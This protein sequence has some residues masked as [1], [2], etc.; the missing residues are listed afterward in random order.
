MGTYMVSFTRVNV[1]IYGDL[2]SL[3][4]SSYIVFYLPI[5]TQ[6]DTV[7]E[8]NHIY[9]QIKKYTFKNINLLKF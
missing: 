2:S 9:F 5:L 3:R 1:M 4:F 8:V 6:T 7:T